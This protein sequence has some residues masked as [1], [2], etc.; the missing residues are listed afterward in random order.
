MVGLADRG[1]AIGG[2][3]GR[4]RGRREPG[5]AMPPRQSAYAALDLGTNSCRLLVACPAPSGFQVVDGFS[6]IVRLGQGVEQS[7]ALSEAAMRRTL[8]AL[9]ICAAKMHRSGVAAARCVATAACRRARNCDSFVDR[10]REETG[11]DLE[12]ISIEEEARLAV[13]GCSSLLEDGADHAL[14]FDIGGGSTQLVWVA[15]GDEAEDRGARILG[16]HALPFGVVSLAERF[17]GRHVLRGTHEA[18]VRQVATML[19]PFEQ[20][21][22]IGRRLAAGTVQMLGTSGTLTTLAAV[23]LGL[24]RYD[25]TRIDGQVLSFDEVSAVMERLSGMNYRERVAQSCIGRQRADLVLGGSAILAAICR[26]WPVGRLR[27][28]DRG[29]REG[30]LLGLMGSPLALT[31]PSA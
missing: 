3:E 13:A 30:I 17:G 19:E 23:H 21:H 28:A 18:M 6:R 20:R 31:P 8:A 10:V 14:M 26:V 25:R 27:V 11:I 16:L 5:D 4:P 24:A 12:I 7:G 29:L 22:G 1:A 2:D 9:R 15:V